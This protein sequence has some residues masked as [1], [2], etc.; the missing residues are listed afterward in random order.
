MGG[1]QG[2]DVG[3]KHRVVPCLIGHVLIAQGIVEDKL[4]A[5]GNR[6]VVE[7]QLAVLEE[8][9]EAQEILVVGA[10][11]VVQ[12][13]TEGREGVDALVAVA[14]GLGVH[15]AGH[16]RIQQEAGGCA[17]HPQQPGAQGGRRIRDR[18]QG[19]PGAVLLRHVH[20]LVVQI[21]DA[22]QR[23]HQHD[24]V[25]SEENQIHASEPDTPA[26]ARRP[27]PFPHAFIPPCPYIK[28]MSGSALPVALYLS[29]QERRDLSK[30]I[31]A[32]QWPQAPEKPP[33]SSKSTLHW[34][35][36]I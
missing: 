5:P 19:A 24:Q 7:D 2:S 14:E 15:H 23:H 17:V 10:D 1:Q 12:V 33:F 6:V 35:A 34:A 29:Y 13:P 8:H 25:G 18:G 4:Q 20:H 22:R 21:Q 30:R 31:P 26:S 32:R 9:A 11:E 36:Y 28:E 16:L 27:A 3:G